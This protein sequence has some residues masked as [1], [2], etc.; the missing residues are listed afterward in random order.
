MELHQSRASR[1]RRW[2][3]RGG[4]AREQ[5]QPPPRVRGHRRLLPHRGAVRGGAQ[6]GG[7]RVPCTCRGGGRGGGSVN[8]LW[9][10]LACVPGHSAESPRTFPSPLVS[11]LLWAGDSVNN[12]P[13]LVA[14]KGLIFHA[15]PMAHAR[16]CRTPGSSAVRFLQEAPG[17]G[18]PGP[19]SLLPA[20]RRPPWIPALAPPPDVW[21]GAG[22]GRA[23]NSPLPGRS[24]QHRPRSCPRPSRSKPALG[25]DVPATAPGQTPAGDPVRSW[26]GGPQ[27]P[28][29]RCE[30]GWHEPP[31]GGT[32]PAPGRPP[33]SAP[34][35]AVTASEW[36]PRGV[37]AERQ[38]LRLPR[39]LI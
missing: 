2:A 26:T 35:G 39:L 25:R 31:A 30:G 38:P 20:P 36:A 24:G 12:T 13:T 33:P 28:P 16:L 9:W 10:Q 14:R 8:K 22:A 7:L 29:G 21:A 15:R 32:A 19:C 1:A 27:G 17:R 3:G 4:R 23:V 11:Q 37:G 6:R 5:G 18:G 34:G